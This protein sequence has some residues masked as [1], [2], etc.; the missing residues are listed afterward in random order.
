MDLAGNLPGSAS[1]E[2]QKLMQRAFVSTMRDAQ[3][4]EPVLNRLL[5][6]AVYLLCWILRYQG[7][8][9]QGYRDGDMP[10]FILMGGCAGAGEALYPIYLS[11]LPVDVLILAPDLNR[12]C[13][14][15]DPGLLELT[16]ADSLP[17]MKFP[18]DAG[19]LQVG[20]LAAHAEDDLAHLLYTDSGI[21]RNRQ[22]SRAD[23]LTLRTTYDEL[24]ILWNQ[25]L[26]YRPGFDTANQTATM[27][28]L[29][30]KFSGV[31]RGDVGA[32]WQKIRQLVDKD[33]FL[34][35]RMP[36]IVPGS[37][38]NW[39][40]LAVKYLRD[41]R[42]KR[43]ALRQ[44]RQYPFAIIREELQEHM[45]DKLQ[46]MLD[47]RLVKGTFENG[48]EYTIVSTVLNMDKALVRLLQSFD[49]TQKNPKL[50]W[51][52]SDERGVSV[53]DAI[54]VAFL[55]LVGFDIALFVPT[56]YQTVERYLNDNLPVE[57]QTGDYLYDLTVPD[58]NALPQPKG[59][60]WLNNLFKRG[61]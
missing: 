27:P 23:S 26:K 39:Q 28:V 60:S 5:N 25:E 42:L 16:G 12:P 58:I 46:L 15:S 52:C 8:L 18:R 11:R 41:G 32:Y 61:N 56:G 17:T 3:R 48:M 54:L 2:L 53:E 13:A 44:D 43:S 37:A 47:R 22:L 34:V 36:M 24:F 51:V 45:L 1:L 59:R 14:L 38:I 9:F 49:F 40:P 31:E 33:T 4:A 7:E 30:A 29:Y 35:R 50:V 20:T 21:Y 10:C 19:T 57:H 55:N 6:S